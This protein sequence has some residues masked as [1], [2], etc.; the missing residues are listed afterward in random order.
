VE[1]IPDGLSMVT[2]SDLNDESSRRIG[3]YRPL[4]A[5][6]EPPDPEQGNWEA[7]EKL[8]GSRIWD[9]DAGPR[10]AMCVVTPTGFGTSSSAL[11]ALPTVERPALKPIF[12]F[13][14]GR[15]DETL[16]HDVALE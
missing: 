7:W 10:G 12:R 1:R 6:A 11:V 14:P 16:W 4:F 9:G 5:N 3:F 2:A 15:P 13:C 8:L